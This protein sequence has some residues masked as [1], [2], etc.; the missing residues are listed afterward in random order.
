MQSSGYTPSVLN[1]DA[2]GEMVEP[3]VAQDEDAQG[4]LAPQVETAVSD[5]KTQVS[6]DR[7]ADMQVS[8]PSLDEHLVQDENSSLGKRLMNLKNALVRF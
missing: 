7:P 5:E 6:T 8:E 1:G 4:S 2:R 3:A